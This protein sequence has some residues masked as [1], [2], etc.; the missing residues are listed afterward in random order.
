MTLSRGTALVA[1]PSYSLLSHI[2][3]LRPANSQWNTKIPDQNE[4]HTYKANKKPDRRE[5]YP[6]WAMAVLLWCWTGYEFETS[7]SASASQFNSFFSI[8]DLLWR[9]FTD[10]LACSPQQSGIWGKLLGIHIIDFQ[11]LFLSLKTLAR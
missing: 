10:I 5:N 4:N 2:L 3:V 8:G 6:V 11:I 9:I 1:W 7:A